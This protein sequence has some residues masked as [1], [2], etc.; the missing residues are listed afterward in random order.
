MTSRIAASW[1]GTAGERESGARE[2]QLSP[3]MTTHAAHLDAIRHVETP[4]GRFRC[5]QSRSNQRQTRSRPLVCPP[6]A[7]AHQ[8]VRRPHRESARQLSIM[9]NSDPFP[10]THT[11]AHLPGHSAPTTHDTGLGRPSPKSSTPAN[12]NGTT[13]GPSSARFRDHG[14]SPVLQL[15]VLCLAFARCVATRQRSVAAPPTSASAGSSAQIAV[16]T[17]GRNKTAVATPWPQH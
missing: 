4:L 7:R 1:R 13:A 6:H 8:P 10:N 9:L 11:R 15:H 12:T 2:C 5:G 3:R 16:V 17:S 14:R